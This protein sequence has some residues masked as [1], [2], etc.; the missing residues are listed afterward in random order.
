MN[1]GLVNEPRVTDPLRYRD[2][3]E[4]VV[5]PVLIERRGDG[6]VRIVMNYPPAARRKARNRFLF[7]S[8]SAIALILTAVSPIGSA[9]HLATIVGSL[10]LVG[11]TAAVA[12]GVLWLQTSM[13]YVFEASSKELCF[14]RCGRFFSRRSC[15]P[16]HGVRDIQLAKKVGGRAVALVIRATHQKL[17]GRY[18]EYLDEQS[19]E[20]IATALREGLAINQPV[21]AK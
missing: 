3:R 7:G 6:S 8:S 5:D 4:G 21:E 18:F 11:V 9:N 1:G 2:G 20:Q 17:A 16:S 19:L 15:F 12:T 14:E 13:T 10:W